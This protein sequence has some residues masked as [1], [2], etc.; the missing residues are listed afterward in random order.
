MGG[1]KK[2]SLK[3]A[4]KQQTLRTKKIEK[5]QRKTRS[6]SPTFDKKR[7]GIDIPSLSDKN[8]AGD[9]SKM[10]AITP[11]LVASKYDVRL[12]T[13]KALLETLDQRGLIQLVAVNS[14]LKLYRF[15]QQDL[16]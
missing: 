9:L 6:D 13:A 7:W 5:T 11:Y 12:S 15:G 16:A 2:R 14:N 1:A 10:K 4:E 8:L 3:Q